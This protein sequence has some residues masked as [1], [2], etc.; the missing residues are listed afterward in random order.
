MRAASRSALELHELFA[1]EEI[2]RFAHSVSSIHW[3]K[4]AL[5]IRQDQKTV[6][7]PIAQGAEF[8][9]GMETGR[10]KYCEYREKTYRCRTANQ[11][12]EW[13]PNSR[14]PLER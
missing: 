10:F 3:R 7:I 5:Y 6:L 13:L 12:R 4:G 1:P 8:L 11:P 14:A 9:F 2:E